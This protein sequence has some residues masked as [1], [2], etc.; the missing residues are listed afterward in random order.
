MHVLI[1][2]RQ[3]ETPADGLDVE[4]LAV[5]H[6]DEF[7]TSREFDRKAVS[8]H[9]FQCCQDKERKYLNC[10]VAYDDDGNAI[11]YLAGTIRDSFYSNRYYAVQ[12]MWYVV[13]RARGTRASIELLVQFER[14]ALFHGV[15]RIYM[16]VEHDHDDSLVHKILR[17][18]SRLGYRTQGYIAVKV[19][20]YTNANKE[21]DNDRSTHRGVGA[22][23]E[24]TAQ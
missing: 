15:E 10:W 11:G 2:V 21:L 5:M 14:W 23:T 7:G 9:A 4:D 24:H 1:S 13:P 3:I 12:E 8:K 16:Q 17:L 19:P 18:M 20:T 6:H 22:V